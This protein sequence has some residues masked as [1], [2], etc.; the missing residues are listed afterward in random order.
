MASVIINEEILQ[1]RNKLKD[2]GISIQEDF[3]RETRTI[4]QSFIPYMLEARNDGKRAYLNYTKLKIDGEVF[5]YEE[6]GDK[7]INVKTKKPLNPPSQSGTNKSR[8]NANG[9]KNVQ[10]RQLRSAAGGNLRSW[11]VRSK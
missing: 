11:V 1:N 4:R 3:S 10:Q 8:T 2:T 5:M 6:E 9:N 7:V